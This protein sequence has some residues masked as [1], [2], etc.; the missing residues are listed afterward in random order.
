MELF[1]R[2]EECLDERDWKITDLERRL[3]VSESHVLDQ[4]RTIWDLVI[5]HKH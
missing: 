4:G 1:G 3:G 5:A 2:M